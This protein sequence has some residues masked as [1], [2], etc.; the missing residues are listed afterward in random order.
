MMERAVL[1]CTSASITTEHL[2]VEKMTRS[3]PGLSERPVASH[4]LPTESGPPFAPDRATDAAAPPARAPAKRDP[5]NDMRQK[6]IDAL[7]ACA[8]NQTRAAAALGVSR[9]TLIN[10]LD[11]YNIPRPRKRKPK[12]SKD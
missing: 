12:V 5:D 8:G 4:R 7:E 1:L 2:P 6:I 9:R 3:T 10:R 11:R